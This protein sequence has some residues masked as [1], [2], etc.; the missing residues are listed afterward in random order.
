MTVVEDG[1]G[2]LYET[3]KIQPVVKRSSCF[4]D[5][6]RCGFSSKSAVCRQ[7]SEGIDLPRFYRTAAIVI[8][9]CVCR[10]LPEVSAHC[11]EVTGKNNIIKIG[12]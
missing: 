2:T 7:E 8:L 3:H 4:I 5:D 12:V 1:I 6:Y 10:T 9:N 11:F